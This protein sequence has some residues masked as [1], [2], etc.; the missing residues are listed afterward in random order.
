MSKEAICNALG[1][2]F[3]KMVWSAGYRPAFP[4]TPQDYS[5]S[6]MLPTILY[7]L[8]WGHR[9]GRGNFLDVFGSEINKLGSIESVTQGL[10]KLND[11]FEGVSGKAEEAI[12]GDLLLCYCFENIRKEEGRD[13]KLIR[14]LPTHFMSS[15]VDLPE[16]SS[17]LR[18]VPE[19]LTAILAH[20]DGRTIIP[21]EGKGH[22]L[23][24]TG[25]DKEIPGQSS[26]LLLS[27]FGEGV[28]TLDDPAKLKSDSVVESVPV[29]ID[30][31]L[32]LRVAEALKEPPRQQKKITK[33]DDSA[34]I[35]NQWPVATLAADRLFED[36]NIFLR[37]Y[38]KKLPRQSLL[39]M[40]E[41]CLSIGLSNVFLSSALLLLQWKDNLNI[42]SK[43]DQMSWSVFVD[44]SNGINHR[45]RRI[46]EETGDDVSRRLLQIPRVMRSL[47]ILDLWCEQIGHELPHPEPD[48]RPHLNALGAVLSHPELSRDLERDMKRHCSVLKGE[49]EEMETDSL[50]SILENKQQSSLYNLSEAIVALMGY[51]NQAGHFRD[52]LDSSLMTGSPNGLSSVRFVNSSTGRTERRSFTLSNTALDFLVHRHLRK[53]GKNLSRTSLSFKEFLSILRDRYGFYVDCSSPNIQVPEEDLR[54]NRNTLERR[55]RELGLFIGVND[56]EA[57]KCLRARFEVDDEQ[58][59]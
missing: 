15:W 13:K 19:M 6:A 22:Y 16:R 29:D 18:S 7:L 52:F 1:A 30:Q 40:L 12:L 46:S 23:V 17:N 33:A 53:A 47:H 11:R 28:C 20:Q 27:I 42:S 43:Q 48:P 9:R 49:L 50:T 36:L 5:L 8:R 4:F 34:S 57:M 21:G 32:M 3:G 37:V 55:L 38:G 25:F 51:S 54:E 59:S 35:P 26:N 10:L 24:R 31:W 41:S 2:G 39:P 44:C 56:A 14:V 45:L 58:E